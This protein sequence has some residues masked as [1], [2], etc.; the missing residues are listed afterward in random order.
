MRRAALEC[1]PARNA[2]A[3]AGIAQLVEQPPCNSDAV[4]VVTSQKAKRGKALG[5]PARKLWD[6]PDTV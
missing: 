4:V 3:F 6:K 5:S 2:P 1:A